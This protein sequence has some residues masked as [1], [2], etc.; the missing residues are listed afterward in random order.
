MDGSHTTSI[1]NERVTHDPEMATAQQ[2][3]APAP[4]P[5]KKA[6]G[7]KPVDPN[8]AE[9][10]VVARLAQLE[11]DAAGDKEQEAEIE[12]EVKKATR[13]LSHLLS[14]LET[15]MLK[16]DTVNKRW[17]ELLHDMKRLER[18]N[19]KAKKK[20]DQL[21]KDKDTQRTELN[22]A[23][24]ARDKL[25]KIARDFQ[26]DN[27]KLKEELDHI[28]SRETSYREDL[29]ERLEVMVRD[30][31]DVVKAKLA[32]E[33]PASDLKLDEIFRQKFRSFI[34]QYEMREI[35]FA[36]LLRTKDLEV[37]FL[38]A[39]FERQRKDQEMESNKSNQLTRK[40]RKCRR[41][42]SA[43]KKRTWSS[44]GSKRLLAAVSSI[45]Q[46]TG[47]IDKRICKGFRNDMINSRSFAAACR[48]KD[49]ARRALQRLTR[50]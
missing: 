9:R 21:Q 20:S 34:D 26:K 44:H 5:A 48:L 2:P 10:Q 49:V 28:K 27:K 4:I 50:T 19:V 40:W 47:P 18:E 31:D 43:W 3:R 13:D 17:Q 32:P 1:P 6:K 46:K 39:K 35:Q 15:P 16:L 29:H 7:K 25:E 45:W 41:R 38:R 37:E 12:R 36:S 14:K 11:Q 8:D 33:P 24:I 30:V 42:R 23:T 22:K